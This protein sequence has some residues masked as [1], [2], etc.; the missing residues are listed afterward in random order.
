VGEGD[1]DSSSVVSVVYQ[2]NVT[3]AGWVCK[4][5]GDFLLKKFTFVSL[6]YIYRI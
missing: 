5:G 3:P 6:N 4:R 1:P 2:W